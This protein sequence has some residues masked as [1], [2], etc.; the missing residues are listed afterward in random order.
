MTNISILHMHSWLIQSYLEANNT[1]LELL[2]LNI[3]MLCI[4]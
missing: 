1:K 2:N 4:I 3:G